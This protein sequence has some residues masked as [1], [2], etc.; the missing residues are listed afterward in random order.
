MVTKI[1]PSE[2]E[3]NNYEFLKKYEFVQA[4][5]LGVIFLFLR[6]FIHKAYLRTVWRSNP[7]RGRDFPH[8]FRPALEPTQPPLQWALD[9]FEG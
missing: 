1:R 8:I 4:L 2:T 6:I 7:G 9:H 5:Y 3:S